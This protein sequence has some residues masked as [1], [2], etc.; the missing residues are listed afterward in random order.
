MLGRFDICSANCHWL[1]GNAPCR[2]GCS[3]HRQAA[4]YRSRYSCTL[5][6]EK[7]FLSRF[8]TLLQ[9]GSLAHAL[10][11][12]NSFR[13][14]CSRSLVQECSGVTSSCLIHLCLRNT[15]LVRVSNRSIKCRHTLQQDMGI[16]FCARQCYRRTIRL[17]LSIFDYSFVSQIPVDGAVIDLQE[18]VCH[19]VV[20]IAATLSVAFA[21]AC[22]AVSVVLHCSSHAEPRLTHMAVWEPALILVYV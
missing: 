22:G 10:H 20:G 15:S 21:Q 13:T 4:R 19:H 14:Y 17:N 3:G 12:S 9:N 1:S 8:Q 5:A 2:L 7:C 11:M 18:S 16:G 6:C